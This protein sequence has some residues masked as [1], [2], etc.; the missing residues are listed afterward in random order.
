MIIEFHPKFKKYYQK[1]ITSNPKLTEQT[2]QRIALFQNNPH[3][4]LLKDHSLVG[5]KSHLRAFSISGNIRIVY[6]PI[7]KDRVLFLN[8]GTHNQVY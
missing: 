3:H 5:K 8:I 7:S 4:P 2:A 6:W 1:R